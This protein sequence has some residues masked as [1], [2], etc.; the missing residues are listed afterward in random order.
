MDADLRSDASPGIVRVDA[1][2]RL[3]AQPGIVG[4]DADLR[5]DAGQASSEWMQI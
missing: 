4:V 5:L 1:D 3:G 2:L